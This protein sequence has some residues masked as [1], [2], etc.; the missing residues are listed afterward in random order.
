[1]SAATDDAQWARETARALL[2]PSLEE[3]VKGRV[4]PEDLRAALTR[5]PLAL[6]RSYTALTPS[7]R[8]SAPQS[9][10]WFGRCPLT[11][12]PHEGFGVAE[13]RGHGQWWCRKCERGGMGGH[14]MIAL[15]PDWPLDFALIHY[16]RLERISTRTRQ[17]TPYHTL[18][19]ASLVYQEAFS[20]AVS[21]RHDIAQRLRHTIWD[22]WRT[23]WAGPD[24]GAE[25]ERL[26]TRLRLTP[27]DLVEAG[28]YRKSQRDATPY[29]L[30]RSRIV[31]PI[32]APEGW[33]CGFIG[34]RHGPIRPGHEPPKYLNT[35]DSQIYHK[36]QVLFGWQRRL[37]CAEKAARAILVEG[38]ID[39]IS[40]GDHL[41]HDLVVAPCG[42]SL[43]IEQLALIRR[44]TDHLVLLYDGD[45]A[46]RAGAARAQAL[47]EPMGFASV[48]EIWLPEGEDPA[49]ALLNLEHRA[50]IIET[51]NREDGGAP[52]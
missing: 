26:S 36:G 33:I 2:S 1:M 37:G 27:H 47:A 7:R 50:H 3:A 40:V 23:G 11:S 9:Q 19:R 25:G 46:G 22:E 24:G 15:H 49:S 8:K 12:D 4:D 30:F 16:L 44:H 14:L 42:T 34:R 13:H 32:V 6:A 17:P 39:A 20:S 43:T 28:L 5:S 45:P 31:W 38:P 35:G 10:I 18:S 29:P 48:R 51:L 52:A 21:P 41:G